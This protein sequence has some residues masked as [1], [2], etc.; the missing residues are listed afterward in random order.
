MIAL[1]YNLLLQRIR[2]NLD[3]KFTIFSQTMVLMIQ[4]SFSFYLNFIVL[5]LLGS[6]SLSADNLNL[7]FTDSIPP[8]PTLNA[9]SLNVGGPFT[10]GIGFSENVYGLT[11]DDFSIENGEVIQ[12]TGGEMNYTVLIDPYEVGIVRFKVPAGV[13]VDEAGNANTPSGTLSVNFTDEEEPI[14]VLETPQS[15]VNDVFPVSVEFNEPVSG[16]EISDFN[17]SNGAGVDLSGSGMSYVL[18]VNPGAVGA[19]SIFLPANVVVDTAGNPNLVSNFLQVNFGTIDITAPEVTLSTS[20]TEVSEPFIVEIRSSEAI[21][22]L[23]LGDF[24]VTNAD[25]SNLAGNGNVF[26]LLATPIV[27]GEIRLSLEAE[28]IVDLF[29]NPNDVSNELVI[30]YLIPLAPDTIR[31]TIILEEILT[32]TEGA[33]A[34]KI[35]FSELV[36]DLSMADLS[37]E[38]ATITSFTENDFEYTVNFTALDFGIVIFSIPE[39]VVGDEA[40]NG[41]IAS[42]IITWEFIDNTPVDPEPILDIVVNRIEDGVQIDWFTNTESYNAFFEIWYSEDGINFNQLNEIISIENSTGLFPYDYLHDS[43][44]FGLNYYFVRQYDLNGDFVDTEIA[45]IDFLNLFPEALIYPNPASNMVT[46]NTT[47]YA[48]TRCEIMVYNT[49]GQIF[50]LEVFEALPNAP[51]EIDI[52]DFQAGVYGVQFWIKETARI[53]SSFV[54]MR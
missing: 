8:A 42:N 6:S 4:Y 51:I 14:V 34:M 13:V 53:E 27:E 40:G 26:T 31:P 41:N 44:K 45:I 37:L 2:F 28:T 18:N 47:Q 20:S 54:I 12:V 25:L 1:Q 22:G 7:L 24:S 49:L 21:T 16:L 23:E 38:N 48:G 15:T 32:G 11:A 19:V 29:D 50:L 3:Q 17:I 36:D 9:G 43:P 52:S 46:F 5:S 39:N 10:V 35:E 30:N 33:Y